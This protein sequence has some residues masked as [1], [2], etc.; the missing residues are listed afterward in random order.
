MVLEYSWDNSECEAGFRSA[1]DSEEEE[2][3]ER[4]SIVNLA[5]KR[6]LSVAKLHYRKNLIKCPC[7]HVCGGS[8]STS[9][10]KVQQIKKEKKEPVLATKKEQV[11]VNYTPLRP[12][13]PA[14]QKQNAEAVRAI[15][16]Q[17]EV[18][19]RK[20]NRTQNKHL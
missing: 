4:P 9:K 18:S 13:S 8:E 14:V 3:E 16:A 2:I 19:I 12:L 15:K 20:P 10:T 5:L 7:G 6:L 1:T 11:P 17:L